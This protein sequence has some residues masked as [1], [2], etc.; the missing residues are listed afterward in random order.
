LQTGW[1]EHLKYRPEI[2]GLRTVAVVPVILYHAGLPFFGGGFVGVDVFFVI[3]GFLITTII[4]EE[5][6][7]QR[8]SI[9][10]FYERRARRILPALFLVCFACLPVAW[11]LMGPADMKYFSRSLLSVLAFLSNIFFWQ[12]AD[13]FDAAA[14]LK[15]LLH[16]WSLAVEEQ[17]YLFFPLL[18]ILAF[19]FGRWISLAVLIVV[20]VISYGLADWGVTR[21]NSAT[22]YLLPTRAW[23]L[24]AGAVLAV[25]MHGRGPFLTNRW[26]NEALALTGLGLIFWAMLSYGPETR[27][28]GFG[29]LPPVLGSV[30]IIGF[31]LP[32]TAVR[33]VLAL[34]PMV[35]IGLISYSAYLWH[36]P[37]F[38]FA[39]YAMVDTEPPPWLMILLALAVL[40]LAWAGWAFV[41][42]PYRTRGR[43]GVRGLVT[44]LSALAVALAGF[45]LAGHLT[46]G[47]PNRSAGVHAGAYSDDNRALREATWND[48]RKRAGDANY[49]VLGNPFDRTAWF[50]MSD[51]RRK[52][53]LVGNSFSKDLYNDFSHSRSA[54]AAFQVARFGT[55]IGQAEAAGLFTSPNYRQADLVLVVSR[56]GLADIQPMK[57]LAKRMLDDGKQVALVMTPFEYPMLYDWSMA[58]LAL[59]RADRQGRLDHDG[60][61]VIAEINA[62][63]FQVYRDAGDESRTAPINAEVTRIGADL[64]IPVLDRMQYRC[65]ADREVCFAMDAEFRKFLPDFS[66]NSVAGAAFFGRRIDETHWL[67]PLLM[68]HDPNTE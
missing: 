68:A 44:S 16:T 61:A 42:A 26:A 56:L 13:Y 39:R 63:Y 50:D 65:D 58:D 25:A 45:G 55:Q 40:P 43:I 10:R 51:P 38:V 24:M 19:R 54:Q 29:A 57:A 20:A 53:L 18:G 22:F 49:M 41:E 59:R 47:F 60:T 27:F 46:A 4:Y 23:E 62:D 11:F 66:H 5:M 2:D 12:E 3:S 28:P 37:L 14:E 17:F 7:E 15:P 30:L 67:D 8:F 36:Q 31:A 34:R 52:L 35:G 9:L 33:R 32:G 6:R 48:L 21:F 1:R 64:G